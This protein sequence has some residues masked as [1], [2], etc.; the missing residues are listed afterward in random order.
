M[1]YVVRKD[2]PLSLGRS[3]ALAGHAALMA[4]DE[5]DLGDWRENGMP[6]IVRAVE[7]DAAWERLKRA[8]DAVVVQDAGLTQ[9]EAGT[10]TVIALAP[11]SAA[12]DGL[13]A[14]P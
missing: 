5:L 1:Y 6:G 7:D 3:M 11:G 12:A 4:A 2:V 10:E 14:V 8:G 9:V 13:S